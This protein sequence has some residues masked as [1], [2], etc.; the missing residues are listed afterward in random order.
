MGRKLVFYNCI[1]G[2]VIDV[3][4]LPSVFKRNIRSYGR[5]SITKSY[6]RDIRVMLFDGKNAPP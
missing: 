1:V 2:G 3:R 6:A 4:Y 5:R